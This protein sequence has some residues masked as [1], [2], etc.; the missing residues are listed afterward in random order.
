MITIHRNNQTFGPYSILNLKLYVE[1][2]KILLNDVAKGENDLKFSTVKQIV[3]DNNLEI[4]IKNNGTLRNQIKSIGKT[5]IFP[6]FDFI[7][8]DLF[9]DKK[10]IYLALIGLAPAFLI[11]FTFSSYFTFYAIALYFSTLWAIFFNNLFK[12]NQVTSKST[13][14]IFF[15]SQIAALILVNL[16]SVPPFSIF[17]SILDSDLIIARLIG[18]ILGVGVLEEF[19]KA[20]PL[21]YLIKNAKEPIIPQTLVFY[22]LMSGIGFGV[23]EGVQYQLTTN[24]KL[25]YNEAFFMNIARLTSLPFL[26]AVWCGISGYFIA[27]GNLFPLNRKGL[28]LLSIAIPA[29]LHGAYDVFGWSII[30]L[31]ITVI[32][33]LLLVFYLK[34][35]KDYQSKL[36]NIN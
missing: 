35:A 28:F 22:G 27:F 11:R 14:R 15:L 13:I 19:I 7:K 8:I 18:Y 4:N 16:Q 12:T 2:G 24:T 31:I 29:I 9:K 36:L 23:F 3:K 32:S 1:E 21:Y 25:D 10:L 5:L 26:H 20:I 33:V 6:S 30:G 34:K 17:Y